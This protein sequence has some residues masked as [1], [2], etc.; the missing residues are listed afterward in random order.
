MR[1]G[2]QMS[3]YVNFYFKTKNDTFISIGDFSRDTKMYDICREVGA[4]WEQLAPFT[5]ERREAALNHLHYLKGKV[6]E[7][8]SELKS[9]LENVHEFE[10]LN[11]NDL[12]TLREN[13]RSE[14]KEWE[15]E[16]SKLDY[17]INFVNIIGKMREGHDYP[18]ET[19]IYFGFEVEGA[20][21]N[22]KNN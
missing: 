2:T 9:E 12:M 22:L 14:I 11:V 19:Q 5:E 1:K 13:L 17:A 3:Q 21:E 15:E 16:T 4:P 20:L 6:R 8:I 7:H 18:H 10:W